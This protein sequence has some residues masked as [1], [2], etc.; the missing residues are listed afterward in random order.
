MTCRTGKQGFAT[1]QDAA[2]MARTV[3]TKGKAARWHKGKCTHY[4]CPMCG[5]WHIGHGVPKGER[6][7]KRT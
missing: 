3:G 4:R 1:A 7:G 2:R 5:Q 6:R